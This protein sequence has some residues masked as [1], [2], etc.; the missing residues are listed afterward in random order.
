MTKSVLTVGIERTLLQFL[1]ERGY[2]VTNYTQAS[3]ERLADTLAVSRYD[4]LLI[5]A[6]ANFKGVAAKHIRQHEHDLPLLR[7]LSGPRSLRWS[8]KC[9]IM[10]EAGVDNVLPD[11][12]EPE[13][14]LRCLEI[15][16]EHAQPKG[17]E[18]LRF[19]IDNTTLEIN[20]TRTSVRVNGA[21]VILTL[22]EYQ[23]LAIIAQGRQPLKKSKI[24]E[25]LYQMEFRQE[26]LNN[27]AVFVCRI[28]KVIGPGFLKTNRGES[29]EMIGRVEH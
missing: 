25:A 23:T 27:L 18:V 3:K 6:G 14:V 8:R 24:I 22:N 13:E 2:A 11:S 17:P 7:L 19:Q 15:A 28:R 10:L 12:S 5:G 21:C 20:L 9:V 1:V 26:W 29:Y 4:A 16:I